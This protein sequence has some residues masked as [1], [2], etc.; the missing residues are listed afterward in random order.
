MVARLTLLLRRRSADQ[1]QV[2]D[3][4]AAFQIAVTGAA[5]V[6]AVCISKVDRLKAVLFGT[7]VAGLICFYAI[8]I[9]S[10]LWSPAPL[11]TGYRA[12]EY[13]AQVAV[14]VAALLFSGSLAQAER[15]LFTIGSIVVALDLVSSVR[16]WGAPFSLESF[17]SASY[18][19]SAGIPACYALGEACNRAGR[20]RRR[21]LMIAFGFMALVGLST[22]S[23]SIIALCIAVAV[24]GLLSRNLV[25]VAAVL[26][27]GILLFMVPSELR[28]SLLF[29]NKDASMIETM[30]GRTGM[31]QTFLPL[32]AE[33]PIFGGGMSVAARLYGS[34]YNI[35]S[36]NSLIAALL[37]TGFSG[38]LVLLAGLFVLGWQSIRALLAARPGSLGCIGGLIFALVNSNTFA[39]FGEDWCV[40]S[41]MFVCM[42]GVEVLFVSGAFNQTRGRSPRRFGELYRPRLC[43]Q[44]STRHQQ[45]HQRNHEGMYR[46]Q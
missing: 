18:G 14:I 20:S 11:F 22:S 45:F 15:R 17:H 3:G 1:F 28:S 5:I 16:A 21:L 6:A 39:F 33:R 7:P 27:A 37:S 32:I 19:I 23:G 29:P 30:S 34:A 40:P 43:S 13:L 25:L 26:L 24:I 2:V 38:V 4:A 9:L 35:N 42:M 12:V 41:V 10:A 36:H 31:W 46:R 44:A 8:C